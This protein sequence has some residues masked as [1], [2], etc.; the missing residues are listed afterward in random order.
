M[1]D[2]SLWQKFWAP[3]I[4]WAKIR[5]GKSYVLVSL[6]LIGGGI[7]LVPTPSWPELLINF[8]AD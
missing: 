7:S 8:F 4:E 1:S 6:A 2:Q 5:K 3:V